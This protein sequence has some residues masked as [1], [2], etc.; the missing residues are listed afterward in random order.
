MSTIKPKSDNLLKYIAEL[1]IDEMIRESIL[2]YIRAG[3]D[4]KGIKLLKQ[5]RS[6]VLTE[7]HATQNRLYQIDFVL[8]KI[9]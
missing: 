6:E 3:Q 2:A 8:Q 5:Y 4:E 9:K 1:D 7:N